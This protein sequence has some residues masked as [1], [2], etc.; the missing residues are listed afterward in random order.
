MFSQMSHVLSHSLSAVQ[1]AL[2][3]TQKLLFESL[4]KMLK[5]AFPKVPADKNDAA[6]LQSALLWGKRKRRVKKR[7]NFLE[8]DGTENNENFDEAEMLEFCSMLTDDP[9]P[10]VQSTRREFMT[11]QM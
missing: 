6:L 5:K 10:K 4:Q 1:K 2:V 8:S 11:E 3:K 9:L 7:K